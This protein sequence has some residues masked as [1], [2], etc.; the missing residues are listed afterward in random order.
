[1]S[2]AWAG[3]AQQLQAGE[4]GPLSLS[5]EL[6]SVYMV[7]PTWWPRGSWT[8]LSWLRV[9]NAHVWGEQG[10]RDPAMEVTQHHFHLL[11]LIRIESLWIAYIPGQKI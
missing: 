5:V 1:M 4:L 9:P 11:L 3:K 10:L 2:G 8:L 6:W 7:F